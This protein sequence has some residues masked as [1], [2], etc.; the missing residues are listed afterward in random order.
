MHAV[1]EENAIA[2]TKESE[3]QSTPKCI[4]RSEKGS[5]RL[6][7]SSIQ[8]AQAWEP[9]TPNLTETQL[10]QQSADTHVVIVSATCWISASNLIVR[11]PGKR[12]G[13]Y[14]P[15]VLIG[16]GFGTHRVTHRA[17][18]PVLPPLDCTSSM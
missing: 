3:T 16:M 7:Q 17:V 8:G 2:F 10:N 11:L 9:T 6:V 1:Q 12:S 15:L 5:P 13:M 4:M 14:E 18:Y